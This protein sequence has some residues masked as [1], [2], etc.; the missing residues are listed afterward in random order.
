MYPS[1]ILRMPIIKRSSYYNPDYRQGQSLIRARSPYLIKN[2][3]TGVGLVAFV[4]S[5]F[6]VLISRTSGGL[7]AYTIHAIKSDDFAEAALPPKKDD[8][9]KDSV[10]NSGSGLRP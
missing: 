3:L 10:K 9:L 6:E 5:I 1:R 4:V 8:I 7:D 2:A